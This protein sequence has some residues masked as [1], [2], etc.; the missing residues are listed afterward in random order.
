[1]NGTVAEVMST[2]VLTVVE[3]TP[4]SQVARELRARNVGSAVVVDSEQK[5]LGMISERE[6]VD[7]VAAGRNPDQG[8]AQLWMRNEFVMTEHTTSK[9]E[10]VELMRKHNVRHLP[11][12]ENGRLVG[13]IS[14][15]DLVITQG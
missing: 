8:T 15:R 7:S 11:I 6:L 13:V 12:S 2:N 4:L 14:V 10:A 1:M 5:P 9:A 3:T